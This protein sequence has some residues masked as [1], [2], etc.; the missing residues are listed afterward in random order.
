MTVTDT[1]TETAH[2]FTYLTCTPTDPDLTWQDFLQESQKFNPRVFQDLT[3]LLVERALCNQHLQ[4]TLPSR[5]AWTQWL[6]EPQTQLVLPA[7]LHYRPDAHP[8]QAGLL[9]QVRSHTAERTASI[10]T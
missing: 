9:L 2:P 5:R 3:V 4:V 7:L 10:H 8:V 6:T 1:S